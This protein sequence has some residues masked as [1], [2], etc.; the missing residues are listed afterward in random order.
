MGLLPRSHNK[1]FKGGLSWPGV[2][3]ID[4]SDPTLRALIQ[5]A[6]AG[7][8]QRQGNPDPRGAPGIAQPMMADASQVQPQAPAMPQMAAMGQAAPSAQMMQMAMQR[9]RGTPTGVFSGN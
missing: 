8:P 1:L 5:Q 7:Q 4:A 9:M 2:Q 3:M 6:M